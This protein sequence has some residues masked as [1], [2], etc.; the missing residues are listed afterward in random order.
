VK[1]LWKG[2]AGTANEPAGEETT[3]EKRSL[4]HRIINS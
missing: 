4:D 1:R 3:K 2:A